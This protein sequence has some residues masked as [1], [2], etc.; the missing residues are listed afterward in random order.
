MT[1]AGDYLRE[2]AEAAD[3]YNLKI[4]EV[5]THSARLIA[6]IYRGPSRSSGTAI[7]DI[8]EATDLPLT[9]KAVGHGLWS[10]GDSN[11]E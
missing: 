9:I 6:S 7:I 2:V 11:A 4:V 3:K 5:G 8:S 10:Q 1:R